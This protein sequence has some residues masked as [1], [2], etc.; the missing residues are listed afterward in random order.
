[1][2]KTGDVLFYSGSWTNPIDV[3]IMT[4]TKSQIV[5][6]GVVVNPNDLR[7][8]P[9]AQ[10][11]ISARSN[12]IVYSSLD[13]YSHVMGVA[14]MEDAIR[15]SEALDWLKAQVGKPYGW[16]DILNQALEL[17]GQ[18]AV[19]LDKSYDCSHLVA[20]FLWI[21]GLQLDA[22]MI[23]ENR[24]TPGDLFR[25]AEARHVLLTEVEDTIHG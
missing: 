8:G 19:L 23:E 5:H 12:G 15:Q 1:M 4:R 13:G 6:T 7:T 9:D 11:L 10:A 17:A 2:P 25:W 16:A 18:N 20:C 14:E 22:W 3:A 24:V 21:A